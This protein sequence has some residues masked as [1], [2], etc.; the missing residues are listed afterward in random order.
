MGNQRISD[1]LKEAVLHMKAREYRDEEILEISQFSL[2]TLKRAARQK[3]L[4]GRV[5]NVQAIG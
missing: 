1:D 2:S 5:T 4:M 3:C